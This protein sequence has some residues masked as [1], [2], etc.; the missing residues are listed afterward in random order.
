MSGEYSN[1]EMQE[2]VDSKGKRKG[3]IEER[4]Q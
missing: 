4:S 1:E 2:A 3:G